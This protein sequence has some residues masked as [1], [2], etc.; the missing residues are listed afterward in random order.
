MFLI[1]YVPHLTNLFLSGWSQV[2]KQINL[3]GIL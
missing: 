1:F 3:L 2:L